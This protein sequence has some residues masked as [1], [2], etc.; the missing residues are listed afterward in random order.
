MRILITGAD[1]QL[2]SELQRVLSR[3][4]LVPACW[5]AFDLLKPTC[6]AFVVDA[7]PAVV[8]HAAAYTDVDGAEREPD[9][10]M[11]VNADGTERIAGA[12]A[13]AGARLICLSTD[14]VFDGRKGAPYEESDETGPLNWYGRSKL[15]AE[16]RALAHCPDT[17]V[18]RTAWL[19]GPQ[20][21]N[22]VKTIMRLAATQSEL[23]VVADQR[24]CPTHAGDLAEALSRILSTD[25]RG[26]VHAA[27]SGDCTWHE[28][29]GAIVAR[30][31][32]SVPVRPI[33]T[34]EAGRAAARPPY[35]VLANRRLAEAG[36]T[37]PHWTEALGRF[38]R[39]VRAAAPTEVS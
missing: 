2:G 28:F 38:M 14:Y 5:P 33:T 22:F 6:E 21:K 27:G 9:L 10:A 29:A 19:Y 13:R 23:R 35:A 4:E 24:G 1:G 11:A 36:I 7:K 34:Q 12:A 26:I 16:R 32:R 39:D 8:I 3:H 31:G 18:V 17:L 30:M 15:E 20:G 37:L 25:L